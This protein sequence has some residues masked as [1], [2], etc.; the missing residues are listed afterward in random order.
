[1]GMSGKIVVMILVLVALQAGAAGA[2]DL[3]LRLWE[4]DD[5]TIDTVFDAQMDIFEAENP[6]VTIART[7]FTTEKLRREFLK[8]ART[9]N[10]PELIL[11]PNDNIGPLVRDG[12]ILPLETLLEK[13]FFDRYDPKVLASGVIDAKV[14]VLPIFNGNNISMFTNRQ[15]VD[16]PPATFEEIIALA[17]RFNDGTTFALAYNDPE[18]FWFVAFLGAFGGSVFDDAGRVTLDT[19]AMVAALRFVRELK[20]KKVVPPLQDYGT[21][22]SMFKAGK[23]AVFFNGLWSWNSYTNLPF[24]WDLAVMPTIAGKPMRPLFGSKGYSVNARL[25][26][27]GTSPRMAAMVKKFLEF[28]ARRDFQ[29]SMASVAGQFPSTSEA[30]ADPAIAGNRLINHAR[31]QMQQGVATPIR[32]EM[33]AVWDAL[34]PGLKEVLEGTQTPE[35]AAAAMQA[36]ALE[37]LKAAA[38]PPAEAKPGK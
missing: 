31:L 27:P 30:L 9:P 20:V 29:L 5:V 11:G 18:P 26:D 2:A 3:V 21:A 19:P 37:M 34:R 24:A 22:E 4:Q 7:H 15:L 6:G 23:A 25:L 13:P 10:G 12:L 8:H 17:D 36:R 16:K 32:V 35:Q 33:R 28:T 14:Y 1:M 38:P